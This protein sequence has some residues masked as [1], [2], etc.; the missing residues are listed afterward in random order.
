MAK[1]LHMWELDTARLSQNPDELGLLMARILE[2][3][4]KD[5]RENEFKDWGEFI[6]GGGGYAIGEGTE[7][8]EFEKTRKY[9]PYLKFTSI[10]VLSNKEV[11]DA[12]M[13]AMAPINKKQS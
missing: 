13:R 7:T 3:V 5:L 6:G 9:V 10:P 8:E 12:M 2:M 1:Y 4:K 11:I